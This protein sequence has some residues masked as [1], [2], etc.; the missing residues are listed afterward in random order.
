MFHQRWRKTL[1]SSESL[2]SNLV[3]WGEFPCNAT[4]MCLTSTDPYQRLHCKSSAL[5]V[6]STLSSVCRWQ[7]RSSNRWTC[8]FLSNKAAKGFSS[9]FKSNVQAHLKHLV[10]TSVEDHTG[11]AGLEAIL[12]LHDTSPIK[13]WFLC[14]SLTAQKFAM[15]KWKSPLIPWIKEKIKALGFGYPR[16]DVCVCVRPVHLWVFLNG[17]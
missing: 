1:P 14:A 13:I 7:P 15:Q 16:K 9:E 3:T 10:Q 5:I 2:W 17:I 12:L 8:I 4:R 11:R 6:S